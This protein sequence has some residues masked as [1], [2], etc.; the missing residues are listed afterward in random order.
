MPGY[1]TQVPERDRWAIVAFVRALERSQNAK[2]ED[3][4]ESERSKLA[5]GGN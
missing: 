1:A 2:L 5:Q 3:V 4:P